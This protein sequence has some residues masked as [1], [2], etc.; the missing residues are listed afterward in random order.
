MLITD[1]ADAQVDDD[2]GDT[3][4]VATSITLGSSLG[5]RI[6]YGS[7]RDVFRLDLTRA[8]GLTDVW[9]HT[10]GELDTVG[11]IYDSSR[12][13]LS[14]SDDVAAGYNNNCHLRAVLSRGVYYIDLRSYRGATGDYAIH[15]RT[16]TGPGRSLTAAT[17]LS[18][19]TPTTGTI[20]TSPDTHYF[21]LDIPESSNVAI[22]ARSGN[23]APV[24]VAVIDES[25]AE[26]A[27][28][29]HQL[30]TRVS[31][32]QA[33]DGFAVIDDF[34]PGRYYLRVA[35]PRGFSR[36]PIPYAILG[37]EDRA[38]TEFIEDCEDGTRSLADPLINDPLYVCQWHLDNPNDFD[39]NIED[40][41]A[42]DI[43][44]VG[45][46][47]AVVDS[48][49][50]HTHEDLAENVDTSRN[51]DYTGSGDI[52]YRYAHHGTHLSGILAA[53]DN[54]I[55]VRGVAP[56]ATLYGYNLLREPTN[57]NE[58]DAM[59]RNAASTAVSN[60][61]W[62]PIDGPGLSTAFSTWESAIE[63]GLTRGY[64]G[65]G[66]FYA[67]AGGNGHLQG[68][69]SNLDEY[70]NHYG[71]TAVCA[72]NDHDTRSSYSEMGANLWVC[73]PS[74][75][76]GH[77][78][79]GIVTTENSDRYYDEFGGTSAATPIVSG[80]V[81]LMRSANPN[82]GWRD[83]KLILAA[84]ARKN[85]PEN[86]G[87]EDGAR[88]YASDSG[89]DRYHF[90]HE[91][92]FGVVDA[93]AAV[94]A[95]KDWYGIPEMEISSAASGGVNMRIPDPRVTDNPTPVSPALS[96]L[97]V[98][99]GPGFTEYVEVNLSIQHH[100]FRD[101]EIELVSP[102]GTVSRLVPALEPTTGDDEFER[103]QSVGMFRFGSAR[104][105]GEDPNGTWQLR[106]TDHV[107]SFGGT[108]V[109]WGIK[110]YGHTGVLDC[111][112]GKAVPDPVNSPGLVSDCQTLVEARYA[113]AGTGKLNWSA[114]T[115]MAD[116]DG[117][118]IAGTPQR[119]TELNLYGKELTGG[120]PAELANLPRL[121]A[122][123]LS[124]N[125]LSGTIPASLGR[126]S[127]LEA[128]DVRGN[129]L[130][131]SM[132]LELGGLSGLRSLSV[133]DNDLTGPIPTWLG[134]LSNLLSL[135]LGGN[136]FTGPI[137][138]E[139]GNLTNLRTLSLSGNSLTGP[140][141]EELGGLTYLKELYLAGNRLDGPV[142]TWLNRL[143]DLYVL[144]LEGNRFTGPIPE[145]LGSLPN[146][147]SLDLSD[148]RLSGAIPPEIGDLSNLR[149][150]FVSG[151]SLEGCLPQ[152]LREVDETD[153]DQLGLPFCDVLLSG[154]AVNPGSLD[155]PFDPYQTEVSA[156]GPSRVTMTAVSEHDAA[157]RF[158]DEHGSEL[159][160]ADPSLDGLQI[161]LGPGV[162]TIRIIVTS[163]DR[164]ATLTYT[165]R[166]AREDLP[167]A[168]VIDAVTPAGGSLAVVWSAPER[169]GGM[170]IT[171][172]DV[173]YIQS[174][175]ADKA[176]AHWTLVDD[177]WSSGSLAYTITGLV[178]GV[179]YDLQ[180][181]AV[182]A[183]GDGL[184]SETHSAATIATG[185]VPVFADGASATRSIADTLVEGADV[186]MPIA[187]SGAAGSTLTY[188]LGG[189]DAGRFTIDEMTGQIMVGAGTEFDYEVPPHT[190]T[191]EVTATGPSGA[192]ATI[193]VTIA[194]IDEH[195]G[196][197][198]T[199]YDAN[200]DRKIDRDEVV[201]AIVDYFNDVITRDEVVKII[202]LYFSG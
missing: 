18:F 120:I 78:H 9:I 110:V 28:N 136:A 127:N 24:D 106:V 187:A 81:A 151:N 174:A 182:N 200:R 52:N 92:G 161:D 5:G 194:V 150:L 166:L 167:G 201:A 8:S 77:E 65:K 158:G 76:R 41:W 71:V 70:A 177:V 105:L 199:K 96:T 124:G 50:D 148:N 82:L 117:V 163:Q 101:L 172:Y 160:D 95:A 85:D 58:A 138:T 39:I 98:A 47:I 48:G 195:L 139:L 49:M 86:P 37:F 185:D 128:L 79:L 168:P 63:H 190:F 104:H 42:E 165:V 16:A 59:T 88:K 72:V 54:D 29:V 134:N 19:D 143:A 179:E 80:V 146:L 198:G 154:L 20:S 121:R 67:W 40:V 90:N 180:V 129:E 4:D 137:P 7:D 25:G 94:D 99:N 43:K 162:T 12:R 33:W 140:V 112:S 171:S 116:W 118:A 125:R 193:T 13:L 17:G 1:D 31:S 11:W 197:L 2:H 102:T 61:S 108:L 126:L 173:R 51:R 69:D 60:N 107:P 38:Y 55:G 149:S 183:S 123:I 178:G 35:A 155:A 122:V 15:A 84:T 132:P 26:I 64:D 164:R 191:V 30:S 186:G 119:V 83:L 57:L 73:A 145:A 184:W 157:L 147:T 91:Y 133:A 113:L 141:P 188:T 176:D 56:R 202:V 6:D 103:V 189:A 89:A 45:V 192:S 75:D 46:N 111:E 74:N 14:F 62:G 68:D 152:N 32:V 135:S 142:P 159:A 181:R 23:F 87:W 36:Y 175:A 156:L 196:A 169:S 115:P 100:S 144:S 170:D 114:Q 131:G 34:E 66:T 22:Y 10:T 130:T 153:L 27:I 21:S 44:G 109:S 53:R 3:F 93:K 97:T